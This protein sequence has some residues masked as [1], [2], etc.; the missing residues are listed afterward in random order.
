MS[1]T[2]DKEAGKERV[3]KVLATAGLG[4]RREIEQWIREGRIRINGR[5]AQLGDR[6][7]MDDQIKLDGKTIHS[8]KIAAAAKNHHIIIYNKPE[9]EI[10]SRDDP[11]GRKTVFRKLPKLP[12]GRW[13]SVG[14]LDINSSGLLIFTTHGELANRLMHPSTEIERE[15]AVRVLGDADDEMLEQLV[16]GVEL[17]DGFARFEEIV[18]SGGGGRNHWFHVV[19]MEGRKREVRRLWEAVGCKVNRLK[20]VRFGPIILDSSV[21]VGQ[22]RELDKN[23]RR[24]LLDMAELPDKDFNLLPKF[25]PSGKKQ[26][27]AGT[28]KRRKPKSVWRR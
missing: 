16:N 13:I 5:L 22:W 20:R 7:D 12:H 18:D 8:E 26:D 15:Y 2:T 21:K 28:Q 17:E 25:R 27:E 4:S 23:E 9:G 3:Q 1:K 19:I 14:R 24:A 10:V 11:D 6:V